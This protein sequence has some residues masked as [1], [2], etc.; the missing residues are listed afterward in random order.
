MKINLAIIVITR[1]KHFFLNIYLKKK[2]NI[3]INL[4]KSENK[5]RY[6]YV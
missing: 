5:N 2:L 1:V 3:K 4:L 6:V